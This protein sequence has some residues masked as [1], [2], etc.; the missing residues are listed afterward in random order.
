MAIENGNRNSNRNARK[1]GN[2]QQAGQREVKEQDE[3]ENNGRK[4]CKDQ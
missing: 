1:P 4:N 3:S 2:R